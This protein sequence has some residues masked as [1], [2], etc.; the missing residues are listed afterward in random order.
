MACPNVPVIQRYASVY[1]RYMYIGMHV[2]YMYIG[3]QRL[4]GGFMYHITNL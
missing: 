2:R 1:V 4:K 3:M